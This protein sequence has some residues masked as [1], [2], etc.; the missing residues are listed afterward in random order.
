LKKQNG[1]EN[2]KYVNDTVIF[3]EDILFTTSPYDIWRS[4]YLLAV[5]KNGRRKEI[6]GDNNI[7][8]KKS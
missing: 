6:N 4:N 1:W 3:S 2:K 8:N 5:I 7:F